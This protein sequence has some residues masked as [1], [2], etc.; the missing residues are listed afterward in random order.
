[1]LLKTGRL[2]EGAGAWCISDVCRFTPF[3]LR[4]L[5]KR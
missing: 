3:K 2:K 4:A 1:M 5:N